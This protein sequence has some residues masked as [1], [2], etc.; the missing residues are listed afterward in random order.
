MLQLE[1]LNKSK[2]DKNPEDFL[3]KI[4]IDGGVNN[5]QFFE[6]E[7]RIKI[8]SIL[9]TDKVASIGNTTHIL[10][11]NNKL[12]GK[13]NIQNLIKTGM[14]TT[15]TEKYLTNKLGQ[16]NLN[17]TNKKSNKIKLIYEN[18]N[19]NLLKFSQESLEKLNHKETLE[20]E[21][22]YKENNS[23]EETKNKEN[24]ILF[25]KNTFPSKESSF[26]NKMTKEESIDG[27]LNFAKIFNHKMS[28]NYFVNQ[29]NDPTR[30][31]NMN[32][33]QVF[34]KMKI[35]NDSEIS[36]E[37]NN[38][39]TVR[40][41]SSANSIDFMSN[42]HN[43]RNQQTEIVN[44]QAEKTK[45]FKA[46]LIKKSSSMTAVNKY[47]DEGLKSNNNKY[48][49][50]KELNYIHQNHED[51]I[52]CEQN[53]EKLI[54][55]EINGKKT[56][57]DL[58]LNLNSNKNKK[59]LNVNMKNN[60]AYKNE[61]IK[62]GNF[63]NYN[64]NFT[65]LN[66]KSEYGTNLNSSLKST[67]KSLNTRNEIFKSTGGKNG[68][69]KVENNTKVEPIAIPTKNQKTGVINSN[70]NTLT[71]QNINSN[72]YLNSFNKPKK[73]SSNHNISNKTTKIDTP[74]NSTNNNIKESMKVPNT[75]ELKDNF[76]TNLNKEI[77]TQKKKNLE[78]QYDGYYIDLIK[79]LYKY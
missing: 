47:V 61:K 20:K 52:H 35:E 22:I 57:V 16:N 39:K 59:I 12:E 58:D 6:I 73:T 18:Q 30:N 38:L 74:I 72:T 75:R 68:Y 23:R 36:K 10:K 76:N 62:F 70:A 8:P 77:T 66:I 7:P 28:P 51:K 56:G 67:L 19:I 43:V 13:K 1:Y 37:E 27:Y 60:I 15:D 41:K 24:K 48:D 31:F 26:S 32:T 14:N 49:E 45:F 5:S 50:A 29:Q 46:N 4:S 3:E 79:L 2:G 63:E 78:K 11:Y 65:H 25:K 53:D 44:N 64:T 54:E 33:I 21:I 9:I 69:I 40:N 71:S 55:S 42:T 34:P 17:P